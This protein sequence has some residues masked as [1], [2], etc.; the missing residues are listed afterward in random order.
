MNFRPRAPASCLKLCPSAF[1]KFNPMFC[2]TGG[3][4]PRLPG[5]LRF[6][7]FGGLAVTHEIFL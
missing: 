4:W 3:S 2:G 6:F 7:S 5:R 1:L